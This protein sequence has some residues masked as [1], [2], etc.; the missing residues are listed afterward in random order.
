MDTPK[1]II[2]D[3]DGVINQDSVDFIKSPKEWIPIPG[4]LEAIAKLKE[5]GFTVIVATNQSGI[6]RHLFSLEHLHNI[7]Q[8][9]NNAIIE[10]GGTIDKIFFCPHL[11]E[12]NCLCRKPKPGLF[13][14]IAKHYDID[15]QKQKIYAIGDSL[16]DLEAAESAG[17]YPILVETGNGKK[18]LANLPESFQHIKSYTHLRAAVEALINTKVTL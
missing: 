16:R 12:D 11:P 7:H 17:A 9:M 8:K 18:T 13:D 14:Q 4:S 1:F 15:Y 6:G 2:L 5:A 10:A 3:R